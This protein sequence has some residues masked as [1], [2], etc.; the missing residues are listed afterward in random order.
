MQKVEKMLLKWLKNYGK[1]LQ[2][3]KE[4]RNFAPTNNKKQTF[5]ALNNYESKR[6]R[7]LNGCSK[8]HTCSTTFIQSELLIR[9]MHNEGCSVFGASL[10][11]CVIKIKDIVLIFV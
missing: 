4:S 5:K 6:N 7:L 8:S 2:N 1:I 11:L 10:F 3:C 9:F